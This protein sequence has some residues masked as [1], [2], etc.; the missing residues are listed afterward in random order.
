V[1]RNKITTE[2]K[3][4]EAICYGEAMGSMKNSIDN[5]MVEIDMA[6]KDKLLNNREKHYE[7]KH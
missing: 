5:S 6:L 1:Q 2:E 3:I 7:V 4:E